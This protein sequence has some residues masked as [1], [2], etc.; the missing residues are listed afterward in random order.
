MKT[1][2]MPVKVNSEVNEKKIQKLNLP[3][4]IAIAF[5]VQYKDIAGKIREILS[6]NHEIT[7]LVQV[8]GCSRLNLPKN[9]DAILLIGSG[10]FHA[11]SLAYESRL[12]VYILEAD[13][14]RKIS[15]DEMSA[16]E[17][18]KKSAYLK[19]LNSE[20]IGI[21]VSTKP[22]QQKLKTAL[23][24][25]KELKEKGKNTYILIGD[26]LNPSEFENFQL[27]SYVNT[28]CPRLDF[29]ASVIN[30]GDL[31]SRHSKDSL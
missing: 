30:S 10:K 28:A 9:T 14:M 24:L 25:K 19:F 29:D 11:V 1:L 17:K 2:F 15:G 18:R 13:K 21:L 4:R 3:K 8:L 6:K 20:N 31:N 7:S 12:P 26:N 22:G 23:Q 27:D 5:S 16:F